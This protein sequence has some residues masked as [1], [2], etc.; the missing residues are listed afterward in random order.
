[1]A[2]SKQTIRFANDSS[3]IDSNGKRWKWS[4]WVDEP[5]SVIERITKVVYTLHPTF[6][7]PVHAVNDRSDRF[8]LRASGWGEF[9][10]D[11][12]VHMKS[13]DVVE[14]SHWLALGNDAPTKSPSPSPSSVSTSSF[15]ERVANKARASAAEGRGAAL[16]AM[17]Q[18]NI[19]GGFAASATVRLFVSSVIS[20]SAI[21]HGLPQYLRSAAIELIS[22]QYDLPAGVPVERWTRR[23][24]AGADGFIGLVGASGTTSVFT[25]AEQAVEYDKPV[26]LVID[27]LIGPDAIPKNLQHVPR[28]EISLARS[29]QSD[30][31]QAIMDFVAKAVRGA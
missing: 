30:F 20:Q 3:P 1:M 31:A 23:A 17:S 21:V 12:A 14:A 11:V 19:G 6:A 25:E 22:A 28:A 4:I 2:D 8:R 15:F 18:S 10:I 24:I 13:G 27:P 9:E 16:R 29:S 7:E 5:P 26:L